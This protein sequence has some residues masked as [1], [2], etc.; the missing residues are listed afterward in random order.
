M[1]LDRRELVPLLGFEV[2][3][4]FEQG[5]LGFLDSS[6][7]F[8]GVE[9]FEF[10][11]L[12][13]THLVNSLGSE[14]ED[15]KKIKND[16]RPRHLGLDGLDETCGHVDGNGFE[17]GAA[18]GTEF[19]EEGVE[20]VG[21]LSLGSPNDSFADVVYDCGD[22]AMPLSVA[23]FVDTDAFQI[24][25]SLGVQLV[26]HDPL[27]DVSY[28]PPGYSHNSGNLGFVGD[29]SQVSGHLLEGSGETTIRP[30]PRNKLY[31]D[32]AVGTFHSP[33]RIFE[34][35]SH[36][37]KT[38]MYPTRWIFAMIVA[39]TNLAAPRTTRFFPGRS[40][41]DYDTIALKSDASYEKIG[42][43]DKNS[44]KLVDAHCFPSVLRVVVDTQKPGKR[45]AF[46]FIGKIFIETQVGGDLDGQL[47]CSATHSQC[48]RAIFLWLFHRSC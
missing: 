13:S 16:L 25:E 30:C 46:Q 21:V 23:E 18:F 38:E 31:A 9:V 22:V 26:F 3:W 36:G 14:L 48:R 10:V 17:F 44:G 34:H 42:N 41:T 29:L 19:V 24:I 37:T 12:L 15:V 43:V 11:D 20:S 5:V 47:M 32:A 28:S 1:F 40:Y 27:N 45:C 33:R 35:D 8:G 7:F 4:V 39:W 6:S 2:P